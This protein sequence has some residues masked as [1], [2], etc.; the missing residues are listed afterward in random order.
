MEIY[1]TRGPSA[2]VQNTFIGYIH[3]ANTCAFL[4]ANISPASQTLTSDARDSALSMV[5]NAAS[6]GSL[7]WRANAGTYSFKATFSGNAFQFSPPWDPGVNEGF[8]YTDLLN[9]S[10]NTLTAGYKGITSDI[11]AMNA[12]ILKNDFSGVAQGGIF[13]STLPNTYSIVAK[14]TL[15]NG[16]SFHIFGSV[17]SNQQR[18]VLQN[19]FRNGAST[20]YDQVSSPVHFNPKSYE[21][22]QIRHKQAL[23]PTFLLHIRN[24]HTNCIS[25]TAAKGMG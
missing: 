19:A 11:S 14:N 17:P 5:G 18:F 20:N 7:G 24:M 21:R 1:Y 9:A 8:S 22:Y 12:F 3:N 4:G 13:I 10:A 2:V 6:G 16:R 15:N 25:A 23:A